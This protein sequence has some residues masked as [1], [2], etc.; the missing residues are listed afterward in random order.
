[1]YDRTETETR[2]WTCRKPAKFHLNVREDSTVTR[3]TRKRTSVKWFA[4]V[5]R[6]LNSDWLFGNARKR[7]RKRQ[8]K[9]QAAE[10]KM[11]YGVQRNR[12][13]PSDYTWVLIASERADKTCS[14]QLTRIAKALRFR[15]VRTTRLVTTLVTVISPRCWTLVF[16]WQPPLLRKACLPV[17]LLCKVRLQVF[18]PVFQP[19]KFRIFR[20]IFPDFP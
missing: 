7:G 12:N 4:A 10:Q 16:P 20:L 6:T 9:N 18:L 11:I 14:S 15:F 13:N 5:K 1:M 17:S 8:N 2:T 19:L 3:K